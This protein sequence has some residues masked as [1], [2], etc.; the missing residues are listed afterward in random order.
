MI[1]AA[2]SRP[3]QPSTSVIGAHMTSRIIGAISGWTRA[4]TAAT[5]S[6]AP[7]RRPAW[8]QSTPAP[9]SPGAPAT[10][11]TEPAPY[12]SPAAALAGICAATAG[13]ASH[14]SGSARTA[15]GMPMSTTID[16]AGVD[17]AGCDV[18]PGLVAVIGHGQV[19]GRA[20]T[21]HVAG[22]RVDARG[23]VERHDRP[24]P[25]PGP[26]DDRVQRRARRPAGSGPQECVDEHRSRRAARCGIERLEGD[27]H[28]Q[29][30]VAHRV[31]V[32]GPSVPHRRTRRPGRATRPRPGGGRRPSRPRRCC[33]FPPARAPRRRRA[34]A[35][36][37][38]GRSRV[39]RAPSRRSTAGRNGGRRPGRPSA[40]RR[41]HRAGSGRQT[42]AGDVNGRS[43]HHHPTTTGHRARKLRRNA[44]G[45]RCCVDAAAPTRSCTPRRACCQGRLGAVVG[46][47]TGRCWRSGRRTV[48]RRSR[49][50]PRRRPPRPCRDCGSARWRSP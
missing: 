48:T 31:G 7:A 27:A 6:P 8:A 2:E 29:R 9:V 35:R 34:S 36:G 23:H 21:L 47:P 4:G 1:S 28:R 24:G 46:P 18:E 25:V 43:A 49:A 12:F 14:A 45:G 32:G 5:T 15:L 13:P 3:K 33:P 37:S 16:L 22:I 39:P 10:T 19:G 50:P 44:Q 30:D 40:V 26:V 41:R 38:H 17:A 11:R 42:A 20:G